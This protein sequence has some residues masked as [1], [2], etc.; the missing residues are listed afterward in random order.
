MTEIIIIRNDFSI[1]YSS[2][3]YKY[4]I[5]SSYKEDDIALYDAIYKATKDTSRYYQQYRRW[6]YVRFL[7]GLKAQTRIIVYC[8]CPNDEIAGVI[9]LKKTPAENKICN[10]RVCEQY[11]R[12]GIA[13]TLIEKS[14]QIFGKQRPLLTISESNYPKFAKLL[15]KYNFKL[16]DTQTGKY[17]GTEKEL[18]F[19]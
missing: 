13:S 3:M 5:I 2:I 8:L 11:Q 12:K 15:E 6:F 18:Y 17:L 1:I 7:Q 14:L 19:I 16:Q 9:L 4:E 10:L